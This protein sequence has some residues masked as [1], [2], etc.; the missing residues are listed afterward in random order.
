[1][2]TIS[3]DL[4]S[5]SSRIISFPELAFINI[6]Y[7]YISKQN[8]KYGN[9]FI[10][11]LN[12]TDHLTTFEMLWKMEQKSNF[13][14][15]RN[16]FNSLYN[17]YNYT[18]SFLEIKLF[19]PRCFQSRRP[20]YVFLSHLLNPFPHI[21]AFWRLCNR[22]LFETSDKRRNFSFCHNVFHF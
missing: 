21:D 2:S 9:H 22:W 14:L 13:S 10:H 18:F 4:L 16:I 15:F 7:I 3:F 11:P 8:L 19:L 6:I 20:K 12:D 5:S 17:S 1:M